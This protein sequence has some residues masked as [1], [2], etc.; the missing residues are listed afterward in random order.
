MTNL[1]QTKIK[2]LYQTHQEDI[3]PFKPKKYHNIETKDTVEVMTVS[4]ERHH[5]V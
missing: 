3:K 5:Y 1:K 2:N 4:P